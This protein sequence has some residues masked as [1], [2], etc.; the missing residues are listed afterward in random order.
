VSTTWHYARLSEGWEILNQLGHR[1]AIVSDEMH[2]HEDDAK[3]IVAAKQAE[4]TV[5]IL[6]LSQIHVEGEIA[7]TRELIR[8]LVQSIAGDAGV[9]S[10]RLKQEGPDTLSTTW[11]VMHVQELA[12]AQ[13]ALAESHERLREIRRALNGGK[14]VPA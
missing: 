10:D 6:R 1:V 8:D 9:L 13:V 5:Q 7:T 11:I 12:K 4:R 14:D 3:L 2:A